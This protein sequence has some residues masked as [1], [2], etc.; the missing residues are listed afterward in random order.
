M[1]CMYFEL[2]CGLFIL[3]VLNV[4]ELYDFGHRVSLNSSIISLYTFKS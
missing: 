1:K 4:L 3:I 2:L